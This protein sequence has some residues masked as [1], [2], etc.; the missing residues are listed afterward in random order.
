MRCR[1][2]QAQD[3]F[4]L[5]R[6]KEAQ[7]RQHLRR[8]VIITPGAVGDCLLM[9]PL[10]KFMKDS[11]RLGGIE[12]IG[13]TEYIDFYP[14]RTCVDGIRSIDSIDFHRL[15]AG[16]KD[17]T[18]E[19]GDALITAFGRY[20]WITSFLGAGDSNF[21]HNLIYTV[22][23]HRAAEVTTLP[24]E[25]KGRFGGHISEFYIGRFNAANALWVAPPKFDVKAGLVQPTQR[26]IHAGK[27]LLCSQGI[28]PA[29]QVAVIHPGSGGRKKCWHLDNFCK[30]AEALAAKDMQVLFLL[31]PVEFERF[32]D[33]A[34]KRIEGVGKYMSG[35][36]LLE[37]I[38]ILACADLYIGND[39]GITHL[40][41]AVGAPTLAVFGPT[42]AQLYRPIGPQVT[43]FS[44]EAESFPKPSAKSAR[45]VADIACKIATMDR[46]QK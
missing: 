32:D 22:N 36:G 10:A 40:G 5:V 19:D 6:Q 33:K 34:A 13:H 24:L 26:D 46:T 20:E 11:C 16:V 27:M 8:G 30:L 45:Q 41:A 23:C 43:L 7:F 1:V 9:L 31:G 25:A 21:E 39:S 4:K 37:V 2:S 17:F 29:G 42:D 44:A 38:Q 15:F 18:V 35:Q 14:G 28:D 12:F 3:I